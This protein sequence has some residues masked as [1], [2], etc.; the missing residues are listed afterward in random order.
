MPF[1][2]TI[3][4]T[5]ANPDTAEQTFRMPTTVQWHLYNIF[6]ACILQMN[7]CVYNIFAE[8]IIYVTVQCLASWR[9][10]QRHQHQHQAHLL[11]CRTVCWPH[12]VGLNTTT[13]ELLFK[14]HICWI[15]HTCH[16]TVFSIRKNCSS[17]SATPSVLM[18]AIPTPFCWP[19]YYNK[20]ILV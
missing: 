9:F 18:N 4:V 19:E 1:C 5:N 6:Y 7:D 14:R 10:V 2:N 15:C 11:C 17:A 12:F 16:C 3:G 13:N 8:F 20:W